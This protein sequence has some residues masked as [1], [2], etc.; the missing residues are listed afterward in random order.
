MEESHGALSESRQCNSKDGNQ[1]GRM[2]EYIAT[3]LH[4]VISTVFS[5]KLHPVISTVAFKI[6]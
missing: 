1:I 2:N 5:I 4:A 6:T 3:T